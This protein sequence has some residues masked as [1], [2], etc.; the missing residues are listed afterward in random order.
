MLCCKSQHAFLSGAGKDLNRQE[1]IDGF[2]SCMAD[3]DGSNG[4]DKQEA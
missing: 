2:R 1:L 4:S 3:A